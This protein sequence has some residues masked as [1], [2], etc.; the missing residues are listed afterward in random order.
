MREKSLFLAL[1]FGLIIV[2]VTLLITSCDTLQY[3]ECIA[4]D[5]TSRPCQ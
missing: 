5:G 2:G 4:R 3:A 1:A